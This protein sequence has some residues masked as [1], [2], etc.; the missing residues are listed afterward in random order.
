M[1]FRSLPSRDRAL[2]YAGSNEDLDLPPLVH[3]PQGNRTHKLERGSRFLRKNKIYGWS[4]SMHEAAAEKRV[5]KRLKNA[6]QVLMPVA[7][8]DVGQRWAPDILEANPAK[9]TGADTPN[10]EASLE[11]QQDAPAS[12]EEMADR[13]AMPVPTTYLDLAM[14]PSM[15]YT[16]GEALKEKALLRTVGDLI[17]G[18]MIMLNVLGD[19]K[20]EVQSVNRQ[21]MDAEEAIKVAKLEQ[22]VSGTPTRDVPAGDNVEVAKAAASQG[23]ATSS[24]RGTAQDVQMADVE[25]VAKVESEDVK[26]KIDPDEPPGKAPLDS[27]VLLGA[28]EAF[29]PPAG[30][31]VTYEPLD[32]MGNSSNEIIDVYPDIQLSALQALFVT[33]TGLNTT[34]RPGLGDP[35]LTLHPTHPQYPQPTVVR[36]TPETQ[37]NSVD[38]SFEKIKELTSDCNAYVRKLE[39]CRERISNMGRARQRVW[40]VIRERAISSAGGDPGDGRADAETIRRRQE[41]EAA[42]NGVETR[43]RRVAAGTGAGA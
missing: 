37:K 20:H 28:T 22:T 42:G 12:A 13:L 21:A 2:F 16:F 5:K 32:Q 10:T 9:K 36:L 39:E 41:L 38:A 8:A 1:S 3:R 11:A 29:Y 43:R 34:I 14:S 35:R 7:C 27:T 15:R 24:V 4:P 40:D 19:L 30:S 23:E 26:P 33:T 25:A 18:E 31:Q 6:L 17:E